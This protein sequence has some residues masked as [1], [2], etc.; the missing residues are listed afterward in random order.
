MVNK[1]KK[2]EQ[3]KFV[4][5]MYKSCKVIPLKVTVSA[6][7][8]GRYDLKVYSPLSTF[9]AKNLPRFNIRHLFRFI[10]TLRKDIDS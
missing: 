2:G 4:K 9:K 7:K 10:E 5:Y 1:H 3:N 8:T 6:A